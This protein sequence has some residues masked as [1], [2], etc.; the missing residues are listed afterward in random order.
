[1]YEF[2]NES[3]LPIEKFIVRQLK[4][5]LYALLIIISITLIGVIGNMWFESISLHDAI[6][7]IS[8]IV[9]GIGPFILPSSVGGKIFFS[10]YAVFVGLVL[11]QHWAWS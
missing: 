5:V 6:L 2:K 11:W 9:A 1:M 3:L 10:L 7:N 8:L 4:H